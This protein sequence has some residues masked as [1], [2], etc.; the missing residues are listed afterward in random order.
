M[1]ADELLE[2]EIERPATFYAERRGWFEFKIM[3][4]SKRSIPDRFYARGGR[5][6]FVEY[7]RPG[8]KP[9]RQQLRRHAEMRE[10]GIEVH[11]IDNMDTAYALFR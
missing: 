4:A 9:T 1:A 8:E 5:L 7:K 2:K 10:H 3:Q 6:L 11:V